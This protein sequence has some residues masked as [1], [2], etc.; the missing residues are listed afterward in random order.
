MSAPRLQDC[1]IPA[2]TPDRGRITPIFSGPPCA[3]RMLNGAVPA[4]RPAAPTPAAK[5]RRD[6]RELRILRL[7]LNS[8]LVSGSRWGPG[9]SPFLI[10]AC[11]MQSPAPLLRRHGLDAVPAAKAAS[12]ADPIVVYYNQCRQQ[13]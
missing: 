9:L 11:N 2:C 12:R 8:S 7:I 6:T 10:V 4:T 5:V 3:R 13:L 1:P